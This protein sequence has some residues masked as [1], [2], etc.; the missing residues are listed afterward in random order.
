MSGQ[1][2]HEANRLP[3]LI[4]VLPAALAAREMGD[5]PPVAIGIEVLV[6]V[7]GDELD[8]GTARERDHGHAAAARVGTRSATTAVPSQG[9]SSAD[10]S[11]H[12]VSTTLTSTTAAITATAMIIHAAVSTP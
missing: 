3:D 1:L 10:D 12:S 8:D 11:S 6:E 2:P 4:D 9:S 7:G 5:E